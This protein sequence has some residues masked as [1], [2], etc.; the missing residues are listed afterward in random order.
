[1][2]DINERVRQARPIDEGAMAR[3]VDPLAKQELLARILSRPT[4]GDTGPARRQRIGLALAAG[5]AGVV[6]AAGTAVVLAT[7]LLDKPAPDRLPATAPD[8]STAAQAAESLP[9]G[10][11]AMR[12]AEEYSPATLAGRGFGFDGTVIEVTEPAIDLYV[13]VTFQVEEWFRGGDTDRFTVSMFPPGEVTSLENTTYQ[14]GSRLLVSGEDRWGNDT[15]TD[16]IA[17]YCGFTRT[18][19]PATADQWRQAFTG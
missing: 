6:V 3:L 19:S 14:L 15:L 17:W 8:R 2:A 10:G 4:V 12:C 18:Y 7:D 16:P 1:M 5:T 11:P 9:L 13:Q